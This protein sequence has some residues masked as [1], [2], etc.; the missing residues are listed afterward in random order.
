MKRDVATVLDEKAES[1][2]IAIVIFV[3]QVA[4]AG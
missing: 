1:R 3:N 4:M 2:G